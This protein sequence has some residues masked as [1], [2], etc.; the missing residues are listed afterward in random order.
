MNVKELRDK[1]AKMND[2]NRVIIYWDDGRENQYFEIEEVSVHR[3][4][5]DRLPN[6][7]VAF[8]FNERDGKDT[9]VFL[10]IHPT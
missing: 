7:K 3:G 4:T 1:L 2:D 10:S 8:R 6:G 9:L 5:S